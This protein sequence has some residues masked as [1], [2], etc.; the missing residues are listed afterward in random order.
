MINADVNGAYNIL[1][2]AVLNAFPSNGKENVELHP[3]H[4]W[5]QEVHHDW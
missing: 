4:W 3:V 1:E 2:K 5:L